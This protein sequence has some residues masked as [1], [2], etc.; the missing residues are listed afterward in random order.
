MGVNIVGSCCGSTPAHT[1]AIAAA[2]A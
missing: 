1:Q 2:I